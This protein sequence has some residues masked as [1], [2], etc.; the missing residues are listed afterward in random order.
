VLA[1]TCVYACVYAR[2]GKRGRGAGVVGCIVR[3][4]ISISVLSR[5]G[6]RGGRAVSCEGSVKARY[7]GQSV[8]DARHKFIRM[9]I[10]Y[11]PH[12][13]QSRNLSRSLHAH[14]AR[15]CESRAT[16]SQRDV[17]G[18]ISAKSHASRTRLREVAPLKFSA[19]ARKEK[20]R[21]KEGERL[22]LRAP[23]REQSPIIPRTKQ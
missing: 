22:A 16:R 21:K 18:T 6:E 12:R 4:Y 3:K 19:L 2:A 8:T 14:R 20:E 1:R 5:E 13:A 10:S 11:N 15:T 9:N 7:R 23:A 17:R